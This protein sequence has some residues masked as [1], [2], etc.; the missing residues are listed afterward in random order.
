[1]AVWS[2]GGD[3][4]DTW[5]TGEEEGATSVAISSSSSIADAKGSSKVKGSSKAGAGSGAGVVG[6]G[7]GITKEETVDVGID[8]R[9]A[10][11]ARCDGGGVGEEGSKPRE[12]FTGDAMDG[13]AT[14][15]GVEDK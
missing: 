3:G 12:R 2:G 7:G 10:R 14:D 11:R 9:G 15:E 5:I 4:K 1:M 6:G 8:F 13:S